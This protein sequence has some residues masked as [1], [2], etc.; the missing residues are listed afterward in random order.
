MSEFFQEEDYSSSFELET[1]K[2]ILKYLLPQKKLLMIAV[3]IATGIAL[4]ETMLP[5]L[6]KYAIDTFL[7]PDFNASENYKIILFAAGYAVFIFLFA[8][9]IRVFIRYAGKIETSV[10]AELRSKAFKRLQ[11]LPFSY[12]DRTPTGWI[13]ARMTSDS[14]KLSNIL[15]WGVIDVV[16]SFM[17]MIIIVVVMFWFNAKLAAVTLSVVPLLILVAIYF[18]KKILKHWRDVRKLTLRLLLHSV[19]ESWVQQLQKH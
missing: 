17:L 11:E 4:L 1:W 5:I 8:S 16:W 14:R 18:R 6:N 19:K 15:A 13:M 12:Y 7:H 3:L 9:M 2:R 10:A